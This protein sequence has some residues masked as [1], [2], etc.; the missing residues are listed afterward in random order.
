MPSPISMPFLI[1]DIGRLVG[2]KLLS[3]ACF[4]CLR[5]CCAR[6]GDGGG[7]GGGDRDADGGGGGGG[8]GG[9]W[10]RAWSALPPRVS[11]WSPRERV[12]R[13]LLT[14]SLTVRGRAALPHPTLTLSLLTLILTL[15]RTL[16]PRL[17][18]RLPSL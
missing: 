16:L 10:G 14:S 5:R 6:C 2:A 9:A 4:R 15:T 11:A 13:D 7:G 8:G 18:L 1:L 3:S 12:V 17:S